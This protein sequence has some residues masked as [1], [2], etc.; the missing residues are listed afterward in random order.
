VQQ[1]DFEDQG[2][3][4]KTFKVEDPDIEKLG[5]SINELTLDQNDI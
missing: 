5:L 3:G 1:F 4:S 2:L